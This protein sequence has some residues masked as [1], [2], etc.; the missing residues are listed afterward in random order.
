MLISYIHWTFDNIVTLRFKL[1]T[2]S[3]GLFQNASSAETCKIQSQRQVGFRAF[4]V[5][6]RMYQFSVHRT[7][8]CTHAS[9]HFSRAVLTVHD[10]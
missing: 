5:K 2:T 4:L 1:M 6:G 3:L 8:H 9:A 7:R 10:E